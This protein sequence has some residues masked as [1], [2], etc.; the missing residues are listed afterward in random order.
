MKLRLTQ[1]VE[2]VVV[3]LLRAVGAEIQ[4]SH[5]VV[6][7]I[8]V[9]LT[10]SHVDNAVVSQ[11]DNTFSRF[12]KIRV[13]GSV[14]NIIDKDVGIDDRSSDRL[15]ALTLCKTFHSVIVYGEFEGRGGQQD[16]RQNATA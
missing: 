3:A 7:G 11:V 2:Q 16:G 5:F 12:G 14:A 13:V 10:A 4:G 15:S 1:S 8:H 9:A 6:H